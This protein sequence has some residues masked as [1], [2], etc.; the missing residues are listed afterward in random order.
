MV[1]GSSF[2]ANRPQKPVRR[3]RCP[4]F[5]DC[6]YT[7]S[8]PSECSKTARK[9]SPGRMLEALPPV[10]PLKLDNMRSR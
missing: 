10:V 6:S 5:D 4:K 3:R 2:R 9:I 1:S 8:R 7:T